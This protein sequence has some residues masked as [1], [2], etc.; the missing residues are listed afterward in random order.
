MNDRMCHHDFYQHKLFH[1]VVLVLVLLH[2]YILD[3]LRFGRLYYKLRIYFVPHIQLVYLYPE[4][5][6]IYYFYFLNDLTCKKADSLGH[7]PEYRPVCVL[8]TGSKLN[9]HPGIFI[10]PS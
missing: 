8:Q 2:D 6:I 3:I 9:K 4:N 7:A 10:P 1:H 5:V